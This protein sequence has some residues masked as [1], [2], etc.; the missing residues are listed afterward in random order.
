MRL[1]WKLHWKGIPLTRAEKRKPATHI[2]T[3]VFQNVPESF[4]ILMNSQNMFQIALQSQETRHV[5]RYFVCHV[6]TGTEFTT[7]LRNLSWSNAWNNLYCEYIT[8]KIETQ[9]RTDRLVR[10]GSEQSIIFLCLTI[11]II[12]HRNSTIPFL[13]ISTLTYQ[14]NRGE[15]LPSREKCWKRSFTLTCLR[16][17][18]TS[19]NRPWTRS[20]PWK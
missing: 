17:K 7:F 14:V 3:K 10:P 16:S 5:S 13:T 8:W 20:L 2:K 6:E 9:S 15:F 12:F 4:R 11:F 1:I 18:S 19:S